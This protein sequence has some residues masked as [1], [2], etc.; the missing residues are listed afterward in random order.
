MKKVRIYTDGSCCQNS[1]SSGKGGYS[2]ILVFENGETIELSGF[3]EV[4]TNNR[5]ELMGVIAALE[6]LK[7]DPHDIEIFCDAA[8]ITDC[9]NQKWYEKWWKNGW[10]TGKQPVKNKLLWV[11]L[12]KN[13][14]PHSVKFRK[15]KGHSGN[16]YN[17][18]CDFLAKQ[19]HSHL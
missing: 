2:S 7:D 6:Y 13:L 1:K 9:F 8:Y 4:T 3:E 16:F 10:K 17:E 18:R 12:M 14:P 15:I 5:M 11:R 19:A